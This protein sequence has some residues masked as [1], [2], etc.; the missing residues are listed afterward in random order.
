MPKDAKSQPAVLIV[1]E[2]IDANSLIAGTLRFLGYATYKAHTEEECLQMLDDLGIDIDA[3]VLI[4][5]IAIEY[6]SEIVSLVRKT[7]PKAR[8]LVI[9]E[10]ESDR[11][12]ILRLKA[13]HV[14]VKPLSA[15]TIAYKV[16]LLLAASGALLEDEKI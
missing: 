5:R 11:T 9:G 8:I 2:D 10:S 7:V 12:G 14:A 15:T 16:T 6:G 13:D 1:E 4:G 3:V